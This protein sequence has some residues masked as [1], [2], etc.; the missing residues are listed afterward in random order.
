MLSQKQKQKALS[1]LMAYVGIKIN[2]DSSKKRIL[3][4]YFQLYED[5]H[6]YKLTEDEKLSLSKLIP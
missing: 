2:L 4:A 3:K 1:T 5:A 6:G